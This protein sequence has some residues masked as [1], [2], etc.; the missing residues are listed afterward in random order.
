M[1]T[2]VFNI[3]ND[4]IEFLVPS[5]T[6]SPKVI[7]AP[8]TLRESPLVVTP[9]LVDLQ[10]NGYMGRDYSSET[11]TESD[12]TGICRDMV[13]IGTLFHVPTIITRPQR[14]I[15]GNLQL[16]AEV[17]ARDPLVGHS[18]VG[19]HIEGPYISTVEGPRG[20]HDPAYIRN[21]SYREFL[22]WQSA[23]HGG[24]R[25]VTVAPELPGALSFIEKITADGVVASIGHSA[26]EP[27]VIRRAVEAGARMSTHLGNGSHRC[28]PRLDNY[29]WEQMACD[30]LDAGLIADGYHLP[31]AALR[32]MARTK[33]VERVV[34]VSDLSPMAGLEPG[35]YEWDRIR[36][37]VGE[38][39]V[40]EVHDSPY[41][42]GAWRSLLENLSVFA[43]A[44]DTSP[45]ATIRLATIRPMR[46]IG[47]ES[48]YR[49]R[50]EHGTMTVLRWD[51]RS[52]TVG[53]VFSSSEGT[54]I[55]HDGDLLPFP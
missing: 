28:L 48:W 54:I 9:G 27:E 46:L 51:E 24:I 53:V 41:F 38:S 49:T 14:V 43:A 23:A 20:A 2:P 18:I 35:T 13:R 52:R 17:R 7:A 26:A 11:L 3:L 47:L 21:P 55:R 45:I 15:V 37:T 6:G 4:S 1:A 33:G 34:L 16:M 44:T 29:L 32:T 22:E 25:I 31:A 39:G 10:V 42:A 50:M 5:A 40:I 19:Y 30:E 8:S 12:I 36:V